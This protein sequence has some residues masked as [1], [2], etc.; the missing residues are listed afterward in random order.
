MPASILKTLCVL[1]HLFFST[2]LGS[3]D[4]YVYFIHRE[5]KAKRGQMT[6]QGT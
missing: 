5:N 2:A 1:P 4:Y 3:R 6:Y